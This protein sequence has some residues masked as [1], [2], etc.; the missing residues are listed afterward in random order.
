M[1]GGVLDCASPYV[2]RLSLL[3]GVELYV[4][5][6]FYG[7]IETSSFRLVLPFMQSYVNAGDFTT[8]GKMRAALFNNAV[9]Y[10]LYM[11]AFIVLLVYAI[12]KGVVINT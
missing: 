2:V 10:G 12:I 11:M 8:A 7:S 1:E 9:Y 5:R 4:L 3:I 6:Y